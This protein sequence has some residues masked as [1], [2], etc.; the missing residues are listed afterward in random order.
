MKII[1][2]DRKGKE[3]GNETFYSFQEVYDYCLND[4]EKTTTHADGALY[5]F[6]ILDSNE[7]F[8]LFGTPKGEESELDTA[9]SFR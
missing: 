9:I 4:L 1:R 7:T 6:K 8:T 3:I 2:V 5:G